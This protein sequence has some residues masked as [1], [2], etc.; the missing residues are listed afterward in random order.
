M[1]FFFVRLKRREGGWH[2]G[3]TVWQWD[4]HLDVYEKPEECCNCKRDVFILGL[5]YSSLTFLGKLRIRTRRWMHQP[6]LKKF[7]DF[8]AGLWAFRFELLKKCSNK[9]NFLW[10]LIRKKIV[11]ISFLCLGDHQVVKIVS[12]CFH[13]ICSIHACYTA[14]RGSITIIIIFSQALYIKFCNFLWIVTG[15]L[16][17]LLFQATFISSHKKENFLILYMT[18]YLRKSL[19]PDPSKLSILRGKIPLNFFQ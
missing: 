2:H 3:V 18:K 12:P 8:W 10:T 17:F 19:A 9:Q 5:S 16:I 6:L 13:T 7:F 15:F 14:K 11:Y 1:N 4:L